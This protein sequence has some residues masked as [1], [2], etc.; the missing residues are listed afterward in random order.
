MASHVEISGLQH[1]SVA[2]SG[3]VSNGEAAS[4]GNGSATYQ[5]V[6]AMLKQLLEQLVIPQLLADLPAPKSEPV[7]PRYR[8]QGIDRRSIDLPADALPTLWPQTGPAPAA[9]A[10]ISVDDVERF[11]G[12]S[13]A[14]DTSALVAYARQILARGHSVE[15][16]FVHLLAPAARLLGEYWEQDRADFVDVTMGLW[17]IQEALH[18]LSALIPG[19]GF[20]NGP[21]KSALFAPIP[22][23]QHS[24][25]ASMLGEFFA[26]NGWDALA[27]V[28][29]TASDIYAECTGRHFDI[30][31]LTVSCDCPSAQISDLVRALRAVSMNSNMHILLGGSAINARP[32]LVQ[33]CG[34]D[35]TAKDAAG[36][37]IFADQLVAGNGVA[38]SS[39]S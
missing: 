4:A 25:G 9:S 15:A 35:G 18:G 8:V 23:D 30:V 22:G 37:L 31:G 26:L 3:D 38:L 39:F 13:V 17:R 28:A 7:V 19:R 33:N 5:P 10:P 11:A 12:L 20:A 36:A 16:L 6:P 27:L 24:F 32:S 21:A 2:R 14:A 1:G 34:A 29:P